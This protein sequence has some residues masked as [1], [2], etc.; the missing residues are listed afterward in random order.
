MDTKA[1]Y[2]GS[3]RGAMAPATFPYGYLQDRE[4]IEAY[5]LIVEASLKR[6]QAMLHFALIE[7][8]EFQDS[9]E[10]RSSSAVFSNL[11][12]S[13]IGTII[14]KHYDIIRDLKQE[15]G[16]DWSLLAANVIQFG[17]SIFCT[18]EPHPKPGGSTIPPEGEARWSTPAVLTL[19]G[20]YRT[21]EEPD[22]AKVL[23]KLDA[24]AKRVVSILPTAA[25]V[26]HV[27]VVPFSLL[28]VEGRGKKL[29][30]ACILIDAPSSISDEVLQDIYTKA[31]LFWLRFCARPF[32]APPALGAL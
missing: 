12:D 32:D 11:P 18:R 25:G 8:I 7:L 23:A 19:P 14:K 1:L 20:D 5:T 30:A 9:G 15:P 28:A 29:G 27:L 24:Y 6:F 26:L 31:Q 2:L 21:T 4:V 17:P 22:E 13:T 3:I 10:R 16:M